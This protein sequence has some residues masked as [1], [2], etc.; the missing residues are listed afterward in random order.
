M[1]RIKLGVFAPYCAD[2]VS[3][4]ITQDIADSVA[5]R[6]GVGLLYRGESRSGLPD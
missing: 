2:R 4:V 3:L 6:D 1:Q 5:L